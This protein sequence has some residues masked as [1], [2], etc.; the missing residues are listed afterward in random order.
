MTPT[1]IDLTTKSLLNNKRKKNLTKELHRELDLSYNSDISIVLK[2]INDDNDAATRING[3]GNAFHRLL[4]VNNKFMRYSNSFIYTALQA[5]ISKSLSGL[6][7]SNKCNELPLHMILS[8]SNLNHIDYYMIHSMIDAC[9]A[10]VSY[11]NKEGLSPLHLACMHNNSNINNY[12]NLSNQLLIYV[13]ILFPP[14]IWFASK[15][16][17]ES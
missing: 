3:N 4:E 16:Q 14:R 10:S 17:K 5:M 1:I 7:V 11:F 15:Q 8:H 9:P 2:I 6:L 12:L 13:L